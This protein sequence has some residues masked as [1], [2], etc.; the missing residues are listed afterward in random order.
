MADEK[1][2][3]K[4]PHSIVLENRH[5]LSLSGVSDVGSFDEQTVVVFTDFG[6]LHIKGVGL[7]I[8][9]LSLDSGEVSIDGEINSLIYTENQ[10]SGGG[11]F[12][13]LFK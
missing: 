11:L 12:S 7:H 2:R 3:Q 9:R 8:S 13:K 4:A 10:A 1:F 6:E 5:A